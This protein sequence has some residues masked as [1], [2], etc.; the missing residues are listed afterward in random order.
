MLALTMREHRGLYFPATD[1]RIPQTIDG[2]IAQGAPYFDGLPTFQFR[3]FASS[4]AHIRNFRHAVDVGAHVGLWSRVFA[5]MFEKVSAF[6]PISINQECFDRNLAKDRG[7]VVLHPYALGAEDGVAEF[8]VKEHNSG[9]THIKV[10]GESVQET[11]IMKRLDDF[12]LQN[13]DFLKIDVEGYELPVIQGGEQM[14]KKWRPVVIVE[15]KPG[16]PVRYGFP[17]LGAVH[18]LQSWGAELMFEWSGDYCLRWKA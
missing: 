9:T 17:Q 16:N 12:D 5:R 15:Q 7:R 4:F 10:D 13:V 14:I 2:E 11:A 18:L 1:V 3:K 6:E 8:R